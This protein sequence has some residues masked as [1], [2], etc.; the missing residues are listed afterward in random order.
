MNHIAIELRRDPELVRLVNY[1]KEDNP[2]PELVPMFKTRVE[3]DKRQKFIKHFNTQNRWKKRGIKINV[4][5]F[6]TVYVGNYSALV[7]VNHI[8]GSVAI[9]IGGIEIGQGIFTQV[10][11]AA[12]NEF[13]VPV[14]KVVVL[15]SANFATPNNY[16]TG[17]SITTQCCA[18]VVIR[19]CEIIKARLASVRA[20]MPNATWQE[21]VFA[22]DQQGIN[23]QAN[24][25]TSP[26]DPRL[27]PY[28]SFGIAVTEVEIDIL[29]GRKWIVRADIFEDTG[30]SINPALDVGQ[31]N[32]TFLC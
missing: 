14:E 23:L 10:A 6:P 21:L 5:S 25:I 9:N 24:Y 2:L 8:D 15:S 26:N 32:K 12:A 16:G 13:N 27:I 19:S 17:S 31:V 3:F 28:S 30:R 18:Y 20:A 29:T 7:S 11:Q 22:A 1:R 4:M